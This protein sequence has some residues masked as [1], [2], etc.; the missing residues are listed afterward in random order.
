[1]RIND[2]NAIFM[3]FFA[4]KKRLIGIKCA[5]EQHI[6]LLKCYIYSLRTLL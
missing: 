1:M 6:S 5:R 2:Y 4:F 3:V